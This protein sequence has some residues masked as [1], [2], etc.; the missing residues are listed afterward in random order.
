MLE[1]PAK[2]A[3]DDCRSM[4]TKPRLKWQRALTVERLEIIRRNLDK[5]DAEIARMLGVGRTAVHFLRQRYKIAKVHGTIQRV[6]R[7]LEKIRGLKPGLSAKAMA[8]Q[9][10][11]SVERA[12][13]YGKLAGYH[14]IGLPE[15]RHFYWR[16]RLKSLPPLLTVSAV[17]RELG[18]AY[19]HAALLCFRHKYKVTI[20][21]GCKPAR[22]P[23]RRWFPRPH[24]ERWL[25]SLKNRPRPPASAVK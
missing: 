13:K 2:N 14:F 25:A 23:I 11:I 20:R 12:K 1:F 18:V 9:L 21:N 22:V 4:Q 15:A 7:R 17:A 16:K 6:Q 19:G 24:H 3:V 10:G 5:T 8:A